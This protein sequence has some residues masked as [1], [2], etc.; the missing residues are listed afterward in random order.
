MVAGAGEGEVVDV[1]E[2]AVG[3]FVDVVDF[4][5][6]AGHVATGRGAATVLG[7]QHDSLVRGGDPFGTAEVERAFGVLVEHAQVVPGVARPSG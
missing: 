4:G 5:E 3:P 6:V 7:V 1:G 2:A